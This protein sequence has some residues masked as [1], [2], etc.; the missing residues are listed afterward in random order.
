MCRRHY[1]QSS[2]WGIYGIVTNHKNK[3]FKPCYQK[4]CWKSLE[5][6]SN[7]Y[8]TSVMQLVYNVRLYIKILNVC[9]FHNCSWSAAQTYDNNYLSHIIWSQRLMAFTFCAPAGHIYKYSNKQRAMSCH[10]AEI[11]SSSC[12]CLSQNCTNAQKLETKS[13]YS[14]MLQLIHCWS[15]HCCILGEGQSDFAGKP[16]ETTLFTS[17]KKSAQI[18]NHT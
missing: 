14:C 1:V 8:A 16:H 11:V 2:T 3:I 18:F 7:F 5:L 6:Y 10:Q 12:I 15:W 13:Q 17:K 4:I 9:C